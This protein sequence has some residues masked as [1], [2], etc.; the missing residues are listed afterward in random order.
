MIP[1]LASVIV[2]NWNSGS[3]LARCLTALGEQR[4]ASLESIVVDNASVDGS[5]EG[6][7]EWPAV[8]IVRNGENVG[9]CRA[10]N[11]GIAL[12]RGEYVL[13]VNPD[14]WVA[15]NFVSQLIGGL[16]ELPQVG[17]ACG[18]LLHGADPQAGRIIDS[19]GLFLNDQRRPYDRGQGE[20]DRGQYDGDRDVFGA[21]G[22]AWACRRA[23]LDDVA[24]AGEILDEDFFAYYDDADLSWRMRLR[25]WLCR[26]IPG[27]EAWH[28]R[29]GGGDLRRAG[30]SPKYAFAQRHALTNRYLMILKN[31][32]LGDLAPHLPAILVTDLARLAYIALRRPALLP[33]FGQAWRLRL[34]ALEKRRLIQAG[35]RV[36]AAEVRRWLG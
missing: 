17:M 5:I 16:D 33:A 2:V 12:A 10:V 1:G 26:Y 22:A 29:G 32:R 36:P 24:C 3:R 20:P 25:G 7:A 30:T 34:R 28:E 35:R 13:S 6:A 21:C 23:A 19:T 15:P 18:K 31:D 8:C 11:Q 4:G 14:V 27:A 9:Y